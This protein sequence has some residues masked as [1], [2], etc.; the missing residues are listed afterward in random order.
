MTVGRP[1]TVVSSKLL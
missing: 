1:V